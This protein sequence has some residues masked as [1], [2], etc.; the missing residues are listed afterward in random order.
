[1]NSLNSVVADSSEFLRAFS[2]CE[3]DVSAGSVSTTIKHHSPLDFAEAGDHS[4][5]NQPAVGDTGSREMAAS[6]ESASRSSSNFPEQ[7]R[8]IV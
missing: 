6:V 5:L 2:P 8:A 3:W 7:K 4:F 1:M